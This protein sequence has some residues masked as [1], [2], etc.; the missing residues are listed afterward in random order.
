MKRF[1][2][3]VAVEDLAANVRF[4]SAMFG[5]APTVLKDDYAKW[6]I[7]DPRVNF[8][9]SSRGLKAGI[10]HLGIQV[11]SGAELAVLRQQTER[12][13]I[14]ALDQPAAACCYARSNKYWTTDPQGV[15]WETFQTLGAI[16]VYGESARKAESTGEDTAACCIP[17]PAE[18]PTTACCGS[19]A[20]SPGN[21]ERTERCCG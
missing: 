20:E 8:A 18:A 11:E 2:V 6:M 16:P 14:A 3:H 1:H 9:I 15:A 17:A 13:E 7:E 19:G 10:N 12:A 4:Y 5:V 21:G